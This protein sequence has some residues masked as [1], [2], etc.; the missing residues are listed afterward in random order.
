MKSELRQVFFMAVFWFLCTAF[1]FFV[2]WWNSNKEEI[3]DSQEVIEDTLT[4]ETLEVVDSYEWKILRLWVVQNNNQFN[5]ALDSS[6]RSFRS[7]Y[8]W[9][10]EIVSISP[11]SF[12]WTDIDV[13]LLLLPYD[14][15]T[16]LNLNPFVFEE[17]IKYGIAECFYKKKANYYCKYSF[18]HSRIPPLHYQSKSHSLSGSSPISCCLALSCPAIAPSRLFLYM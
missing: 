6:I 11:S 10:V 12:S 15:L 3:S 13:D 1:V 18:K 14:L 8:W 16:G 5:S 17:D 7:N 4:G 2:P 9:D